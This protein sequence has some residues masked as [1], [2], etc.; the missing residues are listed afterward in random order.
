MSEKINE[1]QDRADKYRGKV[2]ALF[3]AGLYVADIDALMAHIKSMN[4]ELCYK[5][6]RYTEACDGCRWRIRKDDK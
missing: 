5:C 1:I 2:S 4:N 6:G 3:L